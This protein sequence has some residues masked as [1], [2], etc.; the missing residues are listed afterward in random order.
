[1]IDWRGRVSVLCGSGF[2]FCR[3][4]SLSTGFVKRKRIEKMRVSESP[5]ESSMPSEPPAEIKA[6]ID[7]VLGG[8]K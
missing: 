7:K 1:M 2:R 6:L 3:R 4:W 5:I 8:F